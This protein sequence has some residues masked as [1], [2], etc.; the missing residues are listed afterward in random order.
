[1]ATLN[2]ARGLLQ[3]TA[4]IVVH[5]IGEQRPLETLLGF[6]GD[7]TGR[8]GILE[9][10]DSASYVNPDAV[11][12]RTYLRRITYDASRN[13]RKTVT[14]RIPVGQ[15]QN[16]LGRTVDFYEYYWAYRFRDTTWR[17]VGNWLRSLLHTRRK[18]VTSAALRGSESK[19][20]RA[21]LWA[22]VATLWLGILLGGT[23][24]TAPAVRDLFTRHHLGISNP[25]LVA[26][27]VGLCI[28]MVLALNPL[29]L[30]SVAKIA[31]S[32]I[33][34]VALIAISATMKWDALHLWWQGVT[35]L[36]AI[37]VVVVTR[38]LRQALAMHAADVP[39]RSD[40]ANRKGRRPLVVRNANGLRLVFSTLNVISLGALAVA[41]WPALEPAGAAIAAAVPTIVTIAVVLL[42]GVVLRGVGD[43][44]RYLSN[45]PDDIRQR[46]AIRTGLIEILSRLHSQRDVA[47]GLLKYERIILVGHSLGSVIAYDAIQAYW[48]RVIR[49]IV[50]P[51]THDSITANAAQ[52]ATADEPH[53]ANRIRAAERARL[54][55][56]EALE[57]LPF[58][59]P[60]TGKQETTYNRPLPQVRSRSQWMAAKRDFQALLRYTNTDPDPNNQKVDEASHLDDLPRWIVSDFVSV[61]SPLA[62][63]ELLMAA[64]KADLE[65]SK[66]RRLL[67][68]D[69]PIFT[70]SPKSVSMFR[71]IV[72]SLQPP[73]GDTA[74][75]QSSAPFAAVAWT[76][77]HFQ[78]DL[79]GGRL[80]GIFGN[81]VHDVCLSD[82][83]PYLLNFLVKYPHSSYWP[84]RH[85]RPK[86]HQSRDEL[87]RLLLCHHPVLLI[88]GTPDKIARFQ[89]VLYAHQ[90][91]RLSE[92][93]GNARP[94]SAVVELRLLV[95]TEKGHEKCPA[96]WIWPG[97]TPWVEIDQARQIAQI[98]GDIGLD[99][100]LSAA[101]DS[102]GD[103]SDHDAEHRGDLGAEVFWAEHPGT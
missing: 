24:R 30:I 91:S 9:P 33:A 8:R 71:S 19:A 72:T 60:P 34:L 31:L 93:D 45:N 98:A 10:G 59:S 15:P 85:D 12:E 50:L 57:N 100:R 63:A 65:Q 18:D 75:M 94:Q 44:A 43:A 70:R 86:T 68:A 5:G 22:S 77:L 79:V 62:H 102:S 84:G 55:V 78:H 3:S 40:A 90:P 99:R 47:T 35:A 23:S 11:S 48:A 58:E 92:A 95:V 21:I 26:I 27:C 25:T 41:L 69:P 13:T 67:P 46:E 96:K 52:L 66:Q 17:H 29:G 61:G 16:E 36:A 64:N 2:D 51:A 88:A 97:T 4:V 89:E 6:V 80:A 32:L 87:R 28:L 37:V 20:I 74:R 38:V 53:H 103:N 81:G 82:A 83:K 56:I 7:G 14:D 49:E 101:S 42:S 1:V 39:Q 73:V 76:N 54:E